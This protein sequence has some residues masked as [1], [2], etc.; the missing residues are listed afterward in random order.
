MAAT[1]GSFALMQAASAQQA[2]LWDDLCHN[3]I[4]TPL[5]NPYAVRDLPFGSSFHEGPT[6]A[7]FGVTLGLTGTN[8]YSRDCWGLTENRQINVA[9]GIGFQSG[10][11]GSVQSEADDYLVF[12]FGMPY[13]VGSNIGYATIVTQA[14]NGALTRT[15]WG[16]IDTSFYTASDRAHVLVGTVGGLRTTLRVDQVGDGARFSWTLANNSATP[17][18]AGLWF[19]Q[20]VAF[21]D[22]EGNRKPAGYVYAPGYRP[23][24]KPTRFR[25]DGAGDLDMPQYLTISPTRGD[26]NPNDLAFSGGAYGLRLEN[27]PTE[28][29]NSAFPDLTPVDELRVGQNDL[30]GSGTGLTGLPWEQSTFPDTT[31]DDATFTEYEFYGVVPPIPF[32]T[33]SDTAFVQKWAPQVVPSG[34]SREIVA[35]YRGTWGNANF[36]RPYA[37]VVDAPRVLSVDPASP[38]QYLNNPATFRVYIDNIRG[39]T[40]LDQEIPLED[41]RV[42]LTFP[43]GK[44]G[45]DNGDGTIGATTITRFISRILPRQVGNIDFPIRVSDAANGDVPYTV[46]ITTRTNANRVVNGIIKASAQPRLPLEAGANLVGTPYNYANGSW[47]SILG[48]TVDQQFRAFTWDPQQGEYVIQTGPERG[49]GTWIVSDADLGVRPL[50]GSPSTPPDLGV[51]A[52]L[53]TL[54]SGWNL[55]SNPYPYPVPIGQLVGVSASTPDTTQTYQQLVNSG[56]LSGAVAY[57]DTTLATPQYVYLSGFDEPIQPNRGYWIFVNTDSDL[58]LSFPPVFEPFVPGGFSNGR[59]LNRTAGGS[60]S[61]GRRSNWSLQVAARTADRVDAQNRIGVA[62]DAAS[63]RNL[64]AV[65]APLTPEKKAVA[66]SILGNLGNKKRNLARAFVTGDGTQTFDVQVLSRQGGPVTV[67]FPDIA[68]VPANVKLTLVDAVSRRRIDLRSTPSYAVTTEPRIARNLKI[69]AETTVA[70]AIIR[71]LSATVVNTGVGRAA[72]ADYD[73]GQSGRVTV[74]VLRNGALVATPRNGATQT[75]RAST[76]WNFRDAAGRPVPAGTYTI[77][78]TVVTPSGARQTATVD[79]IR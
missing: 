23:F 33:P 30:G 28:G 9:G 47:E 77:E 71:S 72:R 15:R 66:V 40:T 34:G 52:P 53:I 73:L 49:V 26:I 38:T 20:W 76:T 17:V 2:V 70:Q 60:S 37:V 46:S 51:G 55:I 74:R 11:R 63:A 43:D 31:L 41:V 29:A 21:M 58:T 27:K 6:D 64:S 44:A 25:A 22:K 78:V 67:S 14:A 3:Q 54:K 75:G 57:Y 50:A 62:A 45:L 10:P 35:Y 13:A 1:A 24:R 42:T 12:N 48:L 59:A 79:V 7:L 16:N 5:S 65:H 61:A 4:T 69:V 18:N 8:T 68:A 32:P 39:Y 36:T 56:V 19:G